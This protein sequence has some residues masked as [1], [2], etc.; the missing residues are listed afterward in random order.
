MSVRIT[1]RHLEV[2]DEIRRYVEKK[3][4]RLQ[5][6]TENVQ[7]ID[8]ILDRHHGYEYVVELLLKDGP[9]SIA[10]KTKDSDL[11]RA[12]DMLIDK[13]ERQL[14]KK[15]E[16]TRAATKKQKAKG[17]VVR[18]TGAAPASQASEPEEEE[19]AEG[20]GVA[21]ATRKRAK[22]ATRDVLA[23]L[24]KFGVHVFPAQEAEI[25]TMSVPEAAEELF[26]QDENFLCF[27]D[28]DTEELCIMFR[29]KD[30]NFGLLKPVIG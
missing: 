7:S 3:L 30:G 20:A 29:R 28:R 4:T 21:L 24:E 1:G 13:A 19:S 9:V 27:R 2:T 14:K 25:A 5:R 12:I 22:A 18:K 26:F 15:W 6:L 8:V 10:A 17:A 11:L 16:K 23:T